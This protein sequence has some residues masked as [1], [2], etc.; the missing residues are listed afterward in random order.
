MRSLLPPLA[1]VALVLAGCAAA[2]PGYVPPSAKLDKIKAVTPKGGGIDGQGV[3]QLSEQEQKLDCKGLTGSV[4]VKILQMRQAGERQKPSAAAG[5]AQQAVRPFN[6]STDYG[7]D[8]DADNASDRAR[9]EAL[10][11]QLGAKGCRTFDLEADLKPGNT[12]PPRPIGD[13][14]PKP[15]SK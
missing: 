7:H 1:V 4:V 6:K 14:K 9:L 5:V 11:R 2:M 12:E 15:K 8:L 10:N 3:Y 13:V